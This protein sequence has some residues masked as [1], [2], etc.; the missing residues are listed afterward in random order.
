MTCECEK[1]GF[2]PRRN[3]HVPRHQWKK[4]QSGL[5]EEVDIIIEKLEASRHKI[6]KR[7]KLEALKAR[8][9][10]RKLTSKR[11][12]EWLMFFR[13]EEDTGLGDTAVRLLKLCEGN[14]TKVSLRKRI[15]EIIAEC[16]CSRSKALA[17]LN[18][19]FPYARK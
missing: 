6:K 17:K 4:C 2:C 18:E 15:R 8:I 13:S 1:H 14:P 16:S 19:N 10:R 9:E 3:A 5:V 12:K 11:A 7:H